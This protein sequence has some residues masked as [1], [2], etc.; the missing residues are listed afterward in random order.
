MSG[1]IPRY[2]LIVL[3][4]RNGALAA[5]RT[6]WVV[7]ALIPVPMDRQ[8]YKIR[9]V[10]VA[11]MLL[12]QFAGATHVYSHDLGTP[13]SNACPACTIADNL[14]AVGPA[15]IDGHLPH[16]PQAVATITAATQICSIATL[17]VRQRGP[18]DTP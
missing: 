18:P 3:I 15:A 13:Q 9:L 6:Y 10:F 7:R 12:L 11:A 1:N 17:T 16:L 8:R 4:A 2:L 5:I 14:H